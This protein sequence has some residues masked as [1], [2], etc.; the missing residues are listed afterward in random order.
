VTTTPKESAEAKAI[1]VAQEKHT[2]LEENQA[3][4]AHPNV[5]AFLKA[6]AEAEGGGYDF[7]YGAVKGKRTTPGGSP[8]HRL[9]RVPV[10][11]ARRRPRACI[12]S[13]SIRGANSA[14]R[15]G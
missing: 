13:R 5:A 4:L 10:S 3:Y 11:E 6:I 2:R 1:R 9:I 8:T 7:K 15:W 12:K 14:G